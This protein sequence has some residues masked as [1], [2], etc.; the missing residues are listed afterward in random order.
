MKRSTKLIL[1]AL[2]L[3]GCGVPPD[4]DNPATEAITQ[5]L[6]SNIALR[7]SAGGTY[8]RDRNNSVFQTTNSR[9]TNKFEKW[10]TSG[11]NTSLKLVNDGGFALTAQSSSSTLRTAS[12]STCTSSLCRWKVING[13][14]STSFKLQN[15]SSGLC[16][17][18]NVGGFFIDASFPSACGEVA[19]TQRTCSSS[20]DANQRLF[21]D[22]FPAMAV[23]PTLN[24]EQRRLRDLFL[25]NLAGTSANFGFNANA[26][27]KTS[28]ASFQ[29]T[30]QYDPA[31]SIKILVAV[32]MIRRM[33]AQGTFN[34]DT[35]IAYFPM[36]GSA[37]APPPT[38]PAAGPSGSCPTGSGFSQQASLRD[39][40]FWMLECSDNAAT[41]AIIDFSGGF[42]A[43]NATASSLG[44]TSTSLNVYPGCNITNRATLSNMRTLY[45]KLANGSL[46][47]SANR[48]VLYAN[49]PAAAGDFTGTLARANAIIDNEAPQFNLSATDIANL[50]SKI[51]LR[52]KAGGDVWNG[53]TFLSLTGNA[54]IPSLINTTGRQFSWGI[55]V[56]NAVNPTAANN[57]FFNDD[58]EPLR[59]PIRAAMSGKC[60]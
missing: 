6:S 2:V 42:S 34:F 3:G 26:V 21:V 27:D 32:D 60:W 9:G 37:S 56:D 57:A 40:L 46:I 18:S 48:S 14:L 15:V 53:N 54:L 30:F 35:Q 12:S 10:T 24:D 5:A 31:S 19:L 13:T 59:A 22:T 29:S 43:I 45:N 28:F 58:A 50:K 36:S 11:T 7:F 41:R 25:T 38:C 33:E 8:L 49:M 1:L 39:L 52:Y 55:F 47:S 51:R 17:D 44:M 20:R 4:E 23:D 16:L